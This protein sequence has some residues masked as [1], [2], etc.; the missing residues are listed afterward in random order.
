[1]SRTQGRT[2]W[3]ATPGGGSGPAG[4]RPT[5]TH[6]LIEAQILRLREQ[7]PPHG[8]AYELLSARLRDFSPERQFALQC[9]DCS[10]G[11]R[12]HLDLAGLA[13]LIG[14]VRQPRALGV[15]GLQAAAGRVIDRHPSCPVSASLLADRLI[16]AGELAAA[17]GRP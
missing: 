12:K 10:A 7:V 14:R 15:D 6:S 16:V 4:G 17:E 11:P 9:R 3:A 13:L 1:M 5:V 8:R 2:P